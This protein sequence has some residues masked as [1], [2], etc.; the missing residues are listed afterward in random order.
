MCRVSCALLLLY[1]LLVSSSGFI[2]TFYSSPPPSLRCGG[3]FPLG[4]VFDVKYKGAALG[5][6]RGCCPCCCW[7]RGGGC[8]EA[9]GS[10]VV[11]VDDAAAG[12]AE[13]ALAGCWRRR[14]VADAAGGP[15]G[16]EADVD[17]LPDNLL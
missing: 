9:S 10:V 12:T 11:D 4:T 17:A 15:G 8:S 3:C 13:A 2:Y 6:S 5:T 16:R 7:G 1:T 14:A